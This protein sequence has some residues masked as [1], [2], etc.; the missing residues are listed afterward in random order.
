M[1][2]RPGESRAIDELFAMIAEL[3]RD[4]DKLTATKAL[5]TVSPA[6]TIE[7]A[8]EEDHRPPGNWQ[9]VKE[10]MFLTGR[11]SSCIYKWA[12]LKKIRVF[13]PAGLGTAIQID[14][15]SLP[16]GVRRSANSVDGHTAGS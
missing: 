8:G 10:I 6:T 13:Q 2:A 16:A 12:R 14:L 7:N 4:I 5:C 11:C 3:R 15:D 9:S 1:M